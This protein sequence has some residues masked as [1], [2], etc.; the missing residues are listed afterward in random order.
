MKPFRSQ[1]KYLKFS[2]LV[3]LLE[4]FSLQP[5]KESYFVP[6][7]NFVFDLFINKKV[8]SNV[9]KIIGINIVV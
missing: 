6:L 1:I 3:Y 8:I 5:V 4:Q 9:K 2:G 7:V